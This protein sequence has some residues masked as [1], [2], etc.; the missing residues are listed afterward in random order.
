M[1]KYILYD[2]GA[3]DV[4]DVLKFLRWQGEVTIPDADKTLSCWY[5]WFGVVN[6]E[7]REEY[8]HGVVRLQKRFEAEIPKDA[9]RIFLG[10]GMLCRLAYTNSDVLARNE[11]L[12]HACDYAGLFVSS[13]SESPLPHVAKKTIRTYCEYGIPINYMPQIS[14]KDKVEWVLN[15]T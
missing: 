13:S 14:A 3:N 11:I 12:H 1:N 15:R 5:N 10:S 2:A 8:Q 7:Q 4:D 6:P 9:K